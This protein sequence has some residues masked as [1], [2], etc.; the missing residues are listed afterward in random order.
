[1]KMLEGVRVLDF[2]TNAAGPIV[3]AYFADYG[4]EVIKCEMP[5]GEVGRRFLYYANGMSTYACGKD[6]GKRCLEI[7]L[8]DP[9]AQ[10]L[11]LEQVKNFDLILTANKPGFMEKFGLGYE[12]VKKANPGIIYAS[13]TPFGSA[14]SKYSNKPAYDICAVAMSGLNDQTG[15]ASGPPTRIGAVIGD[16][17]AA[18]GLFSACMLALFHKFRTGE[19]Q[20]V[21]FSM[22]RNMI[23]L[24]AS[25]QNQNKRG[26][27]QGRTGNHNANMSPYGI[28]TG[29]TMSVV[30]G[31]VS[32]NTWNP[33]CD[34]MGRPDLKTAPGFANLAERGQNHLEVERIVT[35]WLNTFEDTKEAYDII[36][37]A[38]VACCP[39]MS[40]AQVWED[41]EYHRLG[42]WVNFPMYPEWEN[43]DAI[44]N[45]HC[46]YFADFSGVSAEDRVPTPARHVGE[47]NYEILKEWGKTEE[48][49][50]ALL[51]QWQASNV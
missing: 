44:S 20:F 29:K 22:V 4:A 42:W 32:P 16:M 45:K 37:K 17:C 9:D 33:L 14:P 43:T 13:L 8:S 19:G 47:D 1:M 15:E 6:R 50:K 5:G 40:A 3:G 36:E 11:I 26:L 38:G 28:Y 25:L 10:K 35:E 18:E 30:I 27:V 24:N 51:T 41:E 7:K 31:A 48:E 2:T 39:V 23:H 49:A 34:C 12:D 21:D 46:P